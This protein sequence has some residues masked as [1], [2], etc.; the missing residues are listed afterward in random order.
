ML[1]PKTEQLLRSH[2]PEFQQVMF[3]ELQDISE[4]KL[5]NNIL[6]N[7]MLNNIPWSQFK[8]VAMSRGKNWRFLSALSDATNQIEAQGMLRL[9]TEIVGNELVMKSAKHAAESVIKLKLQK[10]A[11]GSDPDIMRIYEGAISEVIDNRQ[12]IVADYFRDI[13]RIFG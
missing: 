6:I 3:E 12:R 13:G 9:V 2:R 10:E 8:A 7:A 11:Y 5:H 4:G 1:S